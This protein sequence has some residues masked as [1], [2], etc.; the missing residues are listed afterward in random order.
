MKLRLLIS[1]L[2]AGFIPCLW[3]G[4]TGVTQ[5]HPSQATTARAPARAVQADSADR[6]KLAELTRNAEAVVVV[7]VTKVW[8]SPRQWSGFVSSLQ[9]VDYKVLRI[10]KGSLEPRGLTVGIHLDPLSPLV[11]PDKPEL[12]TEIFTPGK[13][14]VL[15]LKVDKE[16][17]YIA[18][19]TP[20]HYLAPND[21]SGIAPSNENMLADLQRVI[22]KG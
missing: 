12:S 19:P 21:Y 10:L 9:N 15:F 5:A 16:R 3:C 14:H 2:L 18:P 22:S 6:E 1:A 7:E 13:Q 20:H 4:G 11:N 17:W 8:E